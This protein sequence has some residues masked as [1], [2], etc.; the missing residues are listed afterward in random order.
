MLKLRSIAR[1]VRVSLILWLITA[2]IYPLFIL[3][4]AQIPLFQYQAKGSIRV[5]LYNEP[6]GSALIG[7]T[8]TSEEY[9]HSRPSSVLYSQGAKAKPTGISGSSNLAPSN[10]I[11]LKRILETTNELQEESIEPRADLIYTSGSGLDPHITFRSAMQQLDRVANARN[12]RPDEIYPIIIENTQGRFLNIFGEPGVNVLKLN[13][14]L[15]LK[16]ISR[17]QN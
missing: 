5:D 7:Q 8:F 16:E 6:I 15:D 3:L 13:Y 10:P 17:R 2:I 11:L 1:A 12:L 14:A 4:I 9:F